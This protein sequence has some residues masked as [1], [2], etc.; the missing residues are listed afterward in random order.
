MLLKTNVEKM[1]VLCLAKMLMKTQELNH[2]CQD[3]IEKKDSYRHTEI[4]DLGGWQR[5]L[6]G[7]N[8]GTWS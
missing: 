5:R 4:D 8:R 2:V 3:V 6:T 7:Q 1:S